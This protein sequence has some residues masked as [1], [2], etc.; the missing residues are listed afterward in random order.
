MAR[1]QVVCLLCTL[2]IAAAKLAD[3]VGAPRGTNGMGDVVE[4]ATYAKVATFGG[5]GL[6]GS[7][8]LQLNVGLEVVQWTTS[9]ISVP[10]QLVR[11][12][13]GD[14][15]ESQTFAYSVNDA[16]RHVLASYAEDTGCGDLWTGGHWDPTAVCSKGSLNR[17][18]DTCKTKGSDYKC[19]S[20]TFQSGPDGEGS[21][22]YRW[23]NKNA[24]ELGDLSGMKGELEAAAS[25][26]DEASDRVLIPSLALPGGMSQMTAG[27]AKISYE[28]VHGD[29]IRI[30]CDA[31]GPPAAHG[32]NC[33]CL[34]YYNGNRNPSKGS[35]TVFHPVPN[36]PFYHG[37]PG[38]SELEGKSIVFYCGS[39]FGEKAGTP[40]FCAA[41]K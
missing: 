17:A 16:W 9:N 27:F 20:E 13:C 36:T 33:E 40:L 24:C 34:T 15:N 35:M 19:S 39:S 10:A 12:V 4:E 5:D 25:E 14:L 32:T 31:S 37:G 26:G 2:G 23:L 41:L 1:L 22:A 38:F 3:T 6:S 8:T 21:Y 28:S 11:K 18:C 30:N 29:G 7:L